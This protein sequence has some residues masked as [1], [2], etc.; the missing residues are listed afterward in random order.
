VVTAGSGAPAHAAIWAS[1]G[2]EPLLS[3]GEL[4]QS[5]GRSAAVKLIAFAAA[6]NVARSRGAVVV[7]RALV[8]VVAGDAFVVTEDG[9]VVTD[10]DVVAIVVEV[11]VVMAALRVLP[12]PQP[13][14]TPP[15]MTTPNRRD[16]ALFMRSPTLG[17][18]EDSH[19][20]WSD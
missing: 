5:A 17:W 7:D 11:E 13:V 10:D 14:I 4:V 18:S 15:A 1:S 8:D 19:W 12:P 6:V 2:V 16:I 9:V 3:A 20:S